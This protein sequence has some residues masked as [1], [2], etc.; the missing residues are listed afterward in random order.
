MTTIE[1][2]RQD[3]RP[4]RRLIVA[5]LVVTVLY[6]VA[7]AGYL[8]LVVGPAAQ[9]MRAETQP[10]LTVYRALIDRAEALDAASQA[11]LQLVAESEVADTAARA[12]L[13]RELRGRGE[14]VRPQE[15]ARVSPAMQALLGRAADQASAF[16]NRLAEVVA[17]LDLGRA[18]E[19]SL[20]LSEAGALRDQFS[21]TLAQT[22]RLGLTDLLRREELLA[23]ELRRAATAATAGLLVGLALLAAALVALW[24]RLAV[25]LGELDAALSRVAQ[26]ELETQLPVHR[27]DEMGRLS[28]QF[29]EM[30]RVLHARA[31]TQGRFAA[32]GQLVADVAHEVNNPLM[33]IGALTDQHLGDQ[34]LPRELRADLELIRRQARRAGQLLQGLL[35]FVRS[36]EPHVGPVDVNAVLQHAVELVAYQFGV[37]EIT[38]DWQL[39]ARLP[40]ATG[41]A[42][43]LEQ[44]FVNLLSNAVQAMR[45]VPPPRRLVIGSRHHE[46][47]VL[48]S[49]SDSGPGIAP[50]MRD[51]LFR[52]F[53]TSK[54]T[55]GTG[56]GLYISR[57]IVRDLGGDL[58]HEPQAQGA[59]F[60]VAL[61]VAVGAPVPGPER[62]VAAPVPDARAQ[63]LAGL[64][65]LVIDDED[66]VRRPLVRFLTRRGAVV[67]EAANGQDG[68][69]ALATEVPDALLVDL[70]MPVMSGLELFQR[71]AA[72][73]PECTGRVVFLSGDISLA[74]R[75]QL[76]V[77]PERLLL[78]P[79]DLA[80]V[81]LALLGVADARA[82]D[83]VSGS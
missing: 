63:P 45:A 32:A 24:R 62:P 10:V 36:S 18:G 34:T 76:P 5:V 35:R 61:P 4:L 21:R 59:R 74:V 79:V 7:V 40:A 64:R 70:R 33:A 31:E 57:K 9:R 81:E 51:R 12:A 68:L 66:A 47:R 29:N 43:R 72:T 13:R 69:A 8:A 65:V 67:R 25:P 11:A 82:G 1:P 22:E 27:D 48:V 30:T 55:A 78:K 26:G 54:G 50:G 41:D 19:A 16:E 71:L 14:L 52:P 80:T 42:G 2:A 38:L 58:W 28:M 73:W 56:L 15:L 3:R 53:A 75:E 44:V 37:E 49:V 77:P 46:G 39:D 20:R 23:R 17:L 6:V 60:V 83:G